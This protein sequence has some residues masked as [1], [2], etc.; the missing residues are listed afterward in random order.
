MRVPEVPLDT[1]FFHEN[2]ECSG[3]ERGVVVCDN[4]RSLR[5]Y[6]LQLS[7]DVRSILLR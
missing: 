7:N 6:R 1:Q 4:I 2:F 3:V 5:K